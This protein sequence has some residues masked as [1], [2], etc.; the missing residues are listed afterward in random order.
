MTSRRFG[1]FALGVIAACVLLALAFEA[2]VHIPST[3]VLRF[4][5]AVLWLGSIVASTALR[6]KGRRLA[7]G[8]GLAVGTAGVPAALYVYLLRHPLH[9][10]LGD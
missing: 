5:P 10:P 2:F 3:N 9:L 8:V 6:P 7:W 4:S 1:D